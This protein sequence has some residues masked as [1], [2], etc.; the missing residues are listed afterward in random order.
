[1]IYTFKTKNGAT[2]TV[3]AKDADRARVLA[4]RQASNAGLEWSGAKLVKMTNKV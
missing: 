3:S 1:M 4:K 2:F